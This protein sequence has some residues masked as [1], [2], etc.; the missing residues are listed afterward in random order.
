[1]NLAH[2]FDCPVVIEFGHAGLLQPVRSV[3]DAR[4]CLASG[5]PTGGRGRAY[6]AALEACQDALADEL[7]TD[8][9]RQAFIAAAAEVGVFVREAPA[10]S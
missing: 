10:M 9:A 5:W 4:D 2:R 8:A 7:D 1:M 6:I 3:R